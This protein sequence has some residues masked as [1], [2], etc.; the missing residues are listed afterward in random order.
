MKKTLLV[1]T[2]LLFVFMERHVD[3][4]DQWLGRENLRVDPA[5]KA[6]QV[7]VERAM[8]THGGGEEVDG[9]ATG[10]NADGAGATVD[11]PPAQAQPMSAAR[12]ML[13]PIR[14][15]LSRL[16]GSMRRIS[17]GHGRLVRLERARSHDKPMPLTLDDF[18]HAA[19]GEQSPVGDGAAIQTAFNLEPANITRVD[20]NDAPHLNAAWAVR[21]GV[22]GC[23]VSAIRDAALQI[24]LGRAGDEISIGEETANAGALCRMRLK[25]PW[26]VSF[27][28]G[29]NKSTDMADLYERDLTSRLTYRF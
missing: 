29:N 5:G 22:R 9:N 23:N 16:Y 18:A 20:W 24:R 2:I 12:N 4:K 14:L 27:F 1:I 8:F 19:P 15:R 21:D 10:A 3:A 26:D 17:E 28:Y 13:G 11:A 7:Y 25:G 6:G